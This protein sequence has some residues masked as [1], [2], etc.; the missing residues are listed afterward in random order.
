VARRLLFVGIFVAWLGVRGCF[1]FGFSRLLLVIII[2]VVTRAAC[3]S[4]RNRGASEW[5]TSNNNS[6][7]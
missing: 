2:V 5:I 1:F 3:G 7:Y 4:N 6:K